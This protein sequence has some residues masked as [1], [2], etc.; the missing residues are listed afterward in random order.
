MSCWICNGEHVAVLQP[1]PPPVKLEHVYELWI[2]CQSGGAPLQSKRWGGAHDALAGGD[3]L[4]AAVARVTAK[5]RRAVAATY[6]RAELAAAT[7]LDTAARNSA[8]AANNRSAVVASLDVGTGVLGITA[9]CARPASGAAGQGQDPAC[10][11]VGAL[12]L[13]SHV[14]RARRRAAALTPADVLTLC[15]RRWPDKRGRAKAAKAKLKL[16]KTPPLAHASRTGS[17]DSGRKPG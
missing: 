3:T 4:D 17:S 11:R 9:A 6:Q 14:D 1:L 16:R 5:A 12:A 7:K 2:E 15:H 13:G 8:A 10:A